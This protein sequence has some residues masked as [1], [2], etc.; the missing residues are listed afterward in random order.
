[1]ER[2]RG[3]DPAGM[4]VDAAFDSPVNAH[5]VDWVDVRCWIVRCLM[6]SCFGSLC[7]GQAQFNTSEFSAFAERDSGLSPGDPLTLP[8]QGL[9]RRIQGAVEQHAAVLVA[10]PPGSGKTGLIHLLFQ[11]FTLS[12][13]PFVNFPLS[14]HVGTQLSLLQEQ[15]LVQ[16]KRKFP[17]SVRATSLL[18]V[19]Q[20]GVE[21]LIVVDDAHL[22]EGF[23]ESLVKAG[24]NV[25]AFASYNIDVIWN[26][27]VVFRTKVRSAHSPCF[28]RFALM[29][30]A[31]HS[32]ALTTCD[33]P[34]K[35]NGI[36]CIA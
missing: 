1:V 25:L 14:G 18:E 10:G 35:S 30:N 32:S 33:F 3:N 8:R 31:V 22:S 28:P 16:I 15:C 36:S 4:D 34:R 26:T 5:G 19:R 9:L 27:P 17:R 6:L 13:R 21:P 7:A 24:F 2:A 11:A 12:K 29:Q 20:L 23:I